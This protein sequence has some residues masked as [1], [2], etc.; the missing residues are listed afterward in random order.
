MLHLH[1]HCVSC[2]C[3]HTQFTNTHIFNTICVHQTDS[4]SETIYSTQDSKVNIKTSA[5]RYITVR[6]AQAYVNQ[7]LALPNAI[8]SHR[9]YLYECVQER[10]GIYGNVLE[11]ESWREKRRR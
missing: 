9:V 5:F 11:G 4:L 2:L 3:F 8:F 10:N 6:S 1:V 7:F